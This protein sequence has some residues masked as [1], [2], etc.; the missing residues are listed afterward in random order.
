MAAAGAG[1]GVEAA[2]AAA[3]AEP[4]V[5]NSADR[6]LDCIVAPG[7]LFASTL[8]DEGFGYLWS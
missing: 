7:G 5:L 2:A 8:S 3:A 1:A 4:V 6:S